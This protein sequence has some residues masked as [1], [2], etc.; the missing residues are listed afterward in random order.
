[1]TKNILDLIPKHY[2][3]KPRTMDMNSMGQD[4]DYEM[5]Q[6][7][8]FQMYKAGMISQYE[9]QN[10]SELNNEIFTPYFIKMIK[11]T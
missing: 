6:K 9:Y 4:F 7:I 5:A 10:I 2:F 11:I 1:M 8:T 3:K